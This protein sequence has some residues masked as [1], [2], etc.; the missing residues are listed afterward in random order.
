MKTHHVFSLVKQSGIYAL[1]NIAIKV[2][3]L[4]LA[5]FLLDTTYLSLAEY[6]QLGVLLIFAQLSIQFGGLGLG[7]GLLKYVGKEELTDSNNFSAFTAFIASISTAI[8]LYVVFWACSEYLSSLLLGSELKASVLYYL[9]L[10]VGFKIIGAIPMM[11]LRIQERAG[12]YAA[13]IILEMTVLFAAIYFFL[14]VQQRGIEGIILSYAIASGISVSVVVI[15]VILRVKW[16]FDV[17]L[18]KILLRYGAPLVFVG[19]AGIILNAGDRFILKA[20][21]SDEEVGMYEWAARMSGVL[22][23]FVVQSFQLAFTVIGLKALGNGDGAF[24]RRI[25]RHYVVWSGWAALGISILSYEL[26]LLLNGLGASEHYLRS[27]QLVFPLSIGILIYGL[28]VVINNILYAT[29]KTSLMSKNVILSA[30]SNVGLNLVLIPQWGAGGA[31]I[32]TVLSYAILLGLTW[33]SSQRELTI[34]YSWHNLVKVLVLVSFLYTLSQLVVH[35]ELSQVHYI[36]ILILFLYPALV[37]LLR[38]YRTEEIKLG[39][40]YVTDFIKRGSIIG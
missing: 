24:H 15:A 19:L 29:S 21:T 34:Q 25:F 1:G 30:L 17:S 12:V 36:R 14:V 35:L 2:S 11:L 7:T 16:K 5:P 26:T 13:T 3:G 27:T 38:I 22:N 40:N 18:I 32:A 8:V 33:R 37:L 31:A 4:L 6:G 10:Y 28:F 20:I 23:L 9:G 39:L